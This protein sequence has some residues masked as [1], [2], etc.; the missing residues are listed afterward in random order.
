LETPVFASKT[1]FFDPN[2]F[3]NF[4]REILVNSEKPGFSKKIT[5][6]GNRTILKLTKMKNSEISF[7]RRA[8]DYAL[9]LNC[10]ICCNLLIEL[11]LRVPF[12]QTFFNIPKRKAMEILKQHFKNL[13]VYI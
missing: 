10:S 13:T 12:Q 6:L 1:G 7:F 3:P 2:L 5:N 9:M 4:F 11:V 8:L